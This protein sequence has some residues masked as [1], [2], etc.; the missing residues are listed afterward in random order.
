MLRLIRGEGQGRDETLRSRDD[1]AR[2]L[3]SSAA[4]VLLRRITPDRAHEI[5]TR[6]DKAMRLFDRAGRDPVARVLLRRELDNLE[7]VWRE[8]QKR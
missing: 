4:D 8:G 1:V 6:V 7:A 3:V 5:E 2:L